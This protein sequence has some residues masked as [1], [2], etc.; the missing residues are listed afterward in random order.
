MK[1]RTPLKR[2]PFKPR[3][4][5]TVPP[6]ERHPVALSPLAKAP[7]YAGSVSG[8]AV[9]KANMLKSAAYENAVRG[10]GYCVRCGYVCRPQF[11]HRDET[12]GGMLKTDVREGWAGCGPHDNTLGCHY[13]VGTSGT[14]SKAERRAEDLRLGAITRVEVRRRGTWP[15]SV[16][17]WEES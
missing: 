3:E 6:R 12:K 14:L 9:P 16:P 2:T 8:M 17:A 4:G 13:F 15:A 1:Q 11:C 10:L 5:P 7:N